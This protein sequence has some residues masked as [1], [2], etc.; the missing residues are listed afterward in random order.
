MV[1]IG[2]REFLVRI[3]PYDGG[4]LASVDGGDAIDVIGAGR[5][6]SGCWRST[7]DGRQRIVQVARD[8]RDWRADDRAAR[9]HKVQVLPPACRRAVAHMIEKVA[10]G[11]VAAAA[12]ADAGAADAARC[13]GRRQ[14]RAGQPVAVMEAMKMENILRAQGGDGQGDAGQGGRQPRG[15]S[16]DR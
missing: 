12:R 15:R 7:I 3:E 1:R 8:G 4:T 9:A 11:P 14:G 10:A 2:G 13:R 16:G 5:R 6:A